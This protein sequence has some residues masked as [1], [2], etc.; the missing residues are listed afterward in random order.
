MK[1]HSETL[2]MIVG[3]GAGIGL[4]DQEFLTVYVDDL[5]GWIKIQRFGSA[6]HVTAERNFSFRSADL[7][8]ATAIFRL[9][10]D[11]RESADRTR[12]GDD[13]VSG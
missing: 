4:K 3:S 6:L 11:A 5:A 10:D 2:D 8:E 9:S 7:D 1:V 13:D 12:S